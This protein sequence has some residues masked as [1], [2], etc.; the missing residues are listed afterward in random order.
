MKCDHPLY[1]KCPEITTN[2]EVMEIKKT[3]IPIPNSVC[4]D[5]H[6]CF[7]FIRDLTSFS[8]HSTAT[9][10]VLSNKQL[11]VQ[12]SNSHKFTC[13]FTE[14]VQLCTNIL[15]SLFTSR[16]PIL[17]IV[18]ECSQTMSHLCL[19]LSRLVLGENEYF[20]WYSDW[21]HWYY[22]HKMYSTHTF[23]HLHGTPLKQLK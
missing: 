2:K 7:N 8:L 14:T 4:M 16:T 12:S 13:C 5:G 1:G 23:G 22:V 18:K 9:T 11:N 20:Y 3:Y 19:W 10:T 21:C 15:L 17:S 6:S